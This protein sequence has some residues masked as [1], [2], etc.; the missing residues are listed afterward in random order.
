VTVIA[1]SEKIKGL[2]KE[3]GR[4][5]VELARYLGISQQ[6]MRNKFHRNSFSAE[7]LIKITDFLECSLLILV[8]EKHRIFLSKDD[9]R[10][11]K[12]MN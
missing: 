11:S 12:R 1:I 7:D 5:S 10:E 4:K 2:M 8:D 3:K 6:S 9:I